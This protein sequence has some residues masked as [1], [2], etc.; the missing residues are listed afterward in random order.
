[1][2]IINCGRLSELSESSVKN[3]LFYGRSNLDVEVTFILSGA[4]FSSWRREGRF[5]PT[6]Q[7]HEQ[8]NHSRNC[9]QWEGRFPEWSDAVDESPTHSWTW[10]GLEL[11][12]AL[13]VDPKT[14]EGVLEDIETMYLTDSL[15]DLL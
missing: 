1:M 10:N 7:A 13:W 9:I 4:L 12:H 3:W 11:R 6:C 14:F 5:L 8:D 15:W 2:S